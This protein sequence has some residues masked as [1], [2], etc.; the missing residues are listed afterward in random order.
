MRRSQGHIVQQIRQSFP[1][2]PTAE[3][4][5]LM[6]K[7]AHF[8]RS[9]N[10]SSLF[11][12]RGYAGTGKTSVVSS[13]VNTLGSLGTEPVL[14]APTGRAAKVL[15]NYAG[16][17][18]L[19]IHK[20]IYRLQTEADGSM[21]LILQDNKD[22]DSLFIV[23]EASMIPREAEMYQH[24]LFAGNSLLDDLLH[25]V[26]SKQKCRLIFV[27]DTAQLPPVMSADS[28]ALN[29]SYLESRYALRVIDFELQQVVRQAQDSGILFNATR[30]RNMLRQKLEG[31]PALRT[32][33]YPDIIRV[34]GQEAADEVENAFV[35]HGKEDALMICRSN[36][37]ANL[38]NKHIRQ[39]VLFL[40]EE[41]NAGDLL[42]V[43]RNN[44]TWLPEKSKAGFIANGDIIELK[45]IAR[46]ES[47]YGF[48]FADV[49]C[50]FIDY[51]D[52]PDVETK[53]LLD[54]LDSGGPALSRQDNKRL[55]DAVAEDYNEIPNKRSR[56]EKIRKNPYLNALQVKYAY[57][58]TCHKAQGGQWSYVFVEMGYLPGKTPDYEYLR[59]L[60]TAVTR[61][62]GKLFLFNFHDDFF[63][64]SIV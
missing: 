63:E 29:P 32:G 59:W 11:V 3:Q 47:L 26:Y 15:A 27:G 22:Q 21:R 6:D 34:Q 53:L 38:Y 45:R 46:I 16:M 8:I 9:E 58:M 55:F 31:F 12:L 61:A 40:E 64:E 57:A 2:E 1:Y 28:P 24:S 52:M 62:T 50:R 56:L 51:P 13:L 14:L 37:R 41:I 49:T 17:P 39:R 33:P 54:T 10:P 35:S 30:I 23:D 7:L 42:M 36:K 18:A 48:R 5:E 4:E 20:K 43:V 25:F 19:T 44:Y 60:Y